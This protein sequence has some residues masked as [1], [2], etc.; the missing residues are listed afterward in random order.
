MGLLIMFKL[1]IF[2][3]FLCFST[4]RHKNIEA[5]NIHRFP[6]QLLT[7]SQKLCE[8]RGKIEEIHDISVLASNSETEKILSER[9]R[10]IADEYKNSENP[11]LK[12]IQIQIPNDTLPVQADEVLMK[13]NEMIAY[14]KNQGKGR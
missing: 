14:L 4:L 9:L 6:P 2:Q 5:E 3:L 12:D 11:Y 13:I 1:H 8:L 7:F 10:N